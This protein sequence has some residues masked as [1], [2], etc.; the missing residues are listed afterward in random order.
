MESISAEDY[1]RAIYT[2]YEKQGV[3]SAG[4]RSVDVARFLGVSKPSVSEMAKKLA[5]KGFIMAKPYS[6][7]FLTKK[8]LKEAKRLTHNYRVIEV[9][10]SKALCYDLRKI[11]T[12]AH[13]LEHGFSQESI[14]RLDKFLN[15]PKVCPHGDKIH[16]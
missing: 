12:E 6:N 3:S 10:L 11:R 15:N 4:I 16:G 2:H 9:F 13:R 7:I 1:L 14:R 5:K 8:G